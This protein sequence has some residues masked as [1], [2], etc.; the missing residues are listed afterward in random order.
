[1]KKLFVLI[2]LVAFFSGL[3]AQINVIPATSTDAQIKK[4]TILY[5]LPRT[6]FNITVTVETE[7]FF[8]G[9]FS[10]YADKY[11]TI[12]N[13]ETV[14]KVSSDIKSIS[15]IPISEPDPNSAYLVFPKKNNFAISYSPSGV[16]K[17]FGSIDNAASTC[18]VYSSVNLPEFYNG[19]FSFTDLSVKRNFTDIT[20]TTYKVVQFDSV[21]QKIPVYNKV[22]TSKE[23]EQK[24]EEA[25]NFIIKIRKRKFKLMTG[26]FDSETPPADVNAMIKELDELEKEYL[27][28]F[29]GK[30]ITIE[31]DYNSRFIP[32]IN[33][34]DSKLVLFYLSDSKGI[35]NEEI[36][37]SEP[38]YCLLTNF[39]IT[40][41]AD[42]FYNRQN[43][44]KYKNKN[45]GLY[46][47][48]PGLGSIKIALGDVIYSEQRLLIPQFGYTNFLPSAIFKN[49]NLNIIFDENL[50]SVKTISNE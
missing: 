24:A 34:K 3:K 40:A 32:D 25:A 39:G 42:R 7:Y 17:S 36:I 23:Y 35:V 22:I 47:R 5:F 8:P 33:E 1:M 38:V 18:Q 50:G 12:K 19:D 15:I 9:P 21:F 48:M 28:L 29:I 30:S 27:A 31:N 37:D 41:E 49:K 10:E 44:K 43:Q 26:Q 13:V 16:I 11:L 46:Y 6:V 45:K 14:E 20:D 2:I 4:N